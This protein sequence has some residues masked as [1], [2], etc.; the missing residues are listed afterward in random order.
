MSRNPISTAR[1]LVLAVPVLSVVL[2]LCISVFAQDKTDS[3]DK[4]KELKKQRLAL[5]VKIYE[6]T[7]KAH[8]HEPERTNVDQVRQSKA[9][10]FT[11]RLDLAESKDDRIKICEEVIKDAVEWEKIVESLITEGGQMSALDRSKAQ[12]DLLAARIALEKTK[13]SK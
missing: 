12:A 11:A 2:L 3:G 10:V 9:D 7:A 6:G 1:R 4:I 5:L 8:I 13:I